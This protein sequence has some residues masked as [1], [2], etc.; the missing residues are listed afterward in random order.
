MDGDAFLFLKDW[1]HQYVQGFYTLDEQLQFHIRLKE[2]HTL[3]VLES[4]VRIGT[5]FHCT[6][7]ELQL[8]KIAA[9]L[10]DIGR[11]QQYQT[12]RTFNDALSVNHAQL[13]LEVL[14]QSEILTCAGLTDKQLEIVRKAV[15]YHNRRHLPTDEGGECLVAAQITRDADKLDIFAMLVT[16]DKDNKIPQTIEFEN[17]NI[18]SVKIIEDILQGRLV[19]Y[20]DIK[21]ANDL[22]LFRLSWIYDIYFS[23]SFSYVLEEGYLEKLIAMLPNTEDIRCVHRCLRQYAT[24]HAIA[25]KND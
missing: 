10:H 20:P 9:L 4:A 6:F 19:E 18:Y 8:I 25:K 1:F 11:F 13:G 24:S 15:L 23:Y 2:E 16:H 22:L 7:E 5:W 14:Q 17:A 12:Y 21:T 3:R